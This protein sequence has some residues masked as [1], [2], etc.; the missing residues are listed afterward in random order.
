MNDREIWVRITADEF[1]RE[2]DAAFRRV[3]K[4]MELRLL[5]SEKTEAGDLRVLLSVGERYGHTTWYEVLPTPFDPSA[6]ARQGDDGFLARAL[7]VQPQTTE[8]RAYQGEFT[9]SAAVIERDPAFPEYLGGELLHWWQD[10]E[11]MD[12]AG[13]HY[14]ALPGE[15]Q[16]AIGWFVDE[17]S[18][19]L[20]FTLFADRMSWSLFRALEEEGLVRASG[21]LFGTEV[22]HAHIT[23]KG[24][25]VLR[26]LARERKRQL[27]LTKKE[28]H[29]AN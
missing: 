20:D 17:P 29:D 28:H 23:E 7:F 19:R 6:P 10:A 3:S 15:L 27:K 18:K 12:K 21:S 14:R 25:V 13:Q 5:K 9:F 26:Y 1:I 8:H 24:A 11:A 2:V 22:H 16:E 4:G